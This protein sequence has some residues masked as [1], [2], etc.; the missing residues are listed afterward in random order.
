MIGIGVTV[1]AVNTEDTVNIVSPEILCW[2]E[3]AHEML[4]DSREG[5]RYQWSWNTGQWLHCGSELD[6]DESTG[7]GPDQPILPHRD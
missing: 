3:S 1:R 7:G 2:S 6:C 5:R 4:M